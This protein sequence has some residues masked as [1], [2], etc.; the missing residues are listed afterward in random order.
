MIKSKENYSKSSD[1]EPESNKTNYLFDLWHST[2]MLPH[3]WYLSRTLRILSILLHMNMCAGS[4]WKAILLHMTSKFVPHCPYHHDRKVL[5]VEQKW[6]ILCM[7]PHAPP[8][9][10]P[11]KIWRVNVVRGWCRQV[12]PSQWSLI[13]RWWWWVCYIRYCYLNN[14][15]ASSGSHSGHLYLKMPNQSKGPAGW[16]CVSVFEKLS[17]RWMWTD[18]CCSLSWKPDRLFPLHCFLSPP[19]PPPLLPFTRWVNHKTES[20]SNF[21]AGNPVTLLSCWHQFILTVVF[22]MRLFFS[23]ISD[24]T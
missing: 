19:P 2:D 16:M 8:K 22:S 3:T 14:V 12:C 13:L 24:Q 11:S 1:E 23:M 20:S 4:T 10:P 9:L 18:L 21:P 6:Q 17:I 5:S 15:C 7:A